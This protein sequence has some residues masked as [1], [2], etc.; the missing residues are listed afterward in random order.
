MP[1]GNQSF[2]FGFL[3]FYNKIVVIPPVQP[4]DK[5]FIDNKRPVR[6]DKIVRQTASEK[7]Q[8]RAD[9][10][11]IVLRNNA[12]TLVDPFDEQDFNQRNKQRLAPLGGGRFG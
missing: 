6:P 2:G 9:R 4:F 5:I 12:G 10:N 3:K 7:L 11:R 8:R 1:F